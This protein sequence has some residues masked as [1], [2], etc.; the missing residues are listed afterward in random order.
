MIHCKL[1]G[2]LYPPLMA[3]KKKLGLLVH[4]FVIDLLQARAGYLISRTPCGLATLGSYTYPSVN[5][6]N[7]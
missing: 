2:K 3:L 5:A 1:I 4:K 6:A 7:H